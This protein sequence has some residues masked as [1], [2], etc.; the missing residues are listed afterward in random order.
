MRIEPLILTLV[1]ILFI[2]A[3]GAAWS[4]ISLFSS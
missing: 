4:L 3:I 2:F 1:L